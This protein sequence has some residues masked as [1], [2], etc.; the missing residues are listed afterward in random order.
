MIDDILARLRQAYD[1]WRVPN[2]HAIRDRAQRY[3]T[4]VDYSCGLRGCDTRAPRRYE[5]EHDVILAVRPQTWT[6]CGRD[7][8]GPCPQEFCYTQT[9]C[10]CPRAE[11]CGIDPLPGYSAKLGQLR[12]V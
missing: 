8:R 5:P 3:S 11:A 2:N 1:D 7:G 6:F 9:G 10:V 4:E 12:E